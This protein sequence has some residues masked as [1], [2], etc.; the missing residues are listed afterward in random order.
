MAE[1]YYGCRK[2]P[3]HPFEGLI[4]GIIDGG[5]SHVYGKPP[6]QALYGTCEHCN[7]QVIHRIMP[8][9]CP[10]CGEMTRVVLADDR[11]APPVPWERRPSCPCLHGFFWGSSR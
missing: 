8:A 11:D 2:T 1:P 5:R 10:A 9:Y 6:V 3:V 7:W 4:R